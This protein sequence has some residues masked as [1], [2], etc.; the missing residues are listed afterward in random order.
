MRHLKE[1]IDED[2]IVYYV[3]PELDRTDIVEARAYGLKELKGYGEA[4][5]T[6]L[7]GRYDDLKY[8]ADRYLG[9]YE[10]VNGYLFDENGDDIDLDESLKEGAEGK[11]DPNW[12][13]VIIDVTDDE[14]A[15]VVGKR[16][17]KVEADYAK[18]KG[19]NKKKF[20]NRDLVVHKVPKGMFKIGDT[21]DT[22]H[23]DDE[24]FEESLSLKESAGTEDLYNWLKN[25]AFDSGSKEKFDSYVN[26]L[27]KSS[28]NVS[29]ADVIKVV[30]KFAKDNKLKGSF[31]KRFIGESL[32]RESRW[33]YEVDKN[34][35]LSLRE[36]IKDDDALATCSFMQLI[37]DDLYEKI[38]DEDIFSKD[39]LEQYKE[40]IDWL[41]LDA[42][43]ADEAVNYELD[44]LYDFCDS[45]NIWIPINESLT[46]A[47]TLHPAIKKNIKN[48][49]KRWDRRNDE[50][51]LKRDDYRKIA[52]RVG[53][54]EST[55]DRDL[56]LLFPPKK[57]FKYD[58]D[59]SS[60]FSLGL[61]KHD[62]P[63]YVT[64]YEE[65]PIYEPAEGGYYYAG[66]QANSSW[67]FNSK[68]EALEFLEEAVKE[69][70]GDWEKMSDG[71]IER[72]K[73][74][75]ENRYFV[76]EPRN[77]YLSKERGYEPYS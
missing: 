32:L 53:E 42:E 4:D 40:D 21:Y 69:N 17:T 74:I 9:G 3:F 49:Y 14:Q 62:F 39:E 24:Y 59:D 56:D 6:V 1:S 19:L 65:Y 52:T 57:P 51:N 28:F 43:D 11:K 63:F 60:N 58:L 31:T 26:R 22:V 66:V 70:E 16:S 47:D 48:A 2:K 37:Y 29:D 67:G 61:E 71:Y 8:Y 15:P 45:L 44:N 30:K 76:V 12:E 73:Y 50:N 36:A 23:W 55:I 13:Y 46:E 7:S 25:H 34:L 5:E 33:E 64:Y 77:S 41:D 75:G 38:N 35:A 27:K 72:S 18:I 54:D 68:D 20:E 10:L